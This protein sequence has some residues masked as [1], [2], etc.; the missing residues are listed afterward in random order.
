MLWGKFVLNEEVTPK[1]EI[2]VCWILAAHVLILPV[3][4]NFCDQNFRF[5]I[6]PLNNRTIAVGNS[7]DI[8]ISEWQREEFASDRNQRGRG[9]KLFVWQRLLLVWDTVFLMLSNAV[10]VGVYFNGVRQ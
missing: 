5:R 6:G 9:A 10:V 8:I 3:D 2:Q 1:N 7:K 4:F